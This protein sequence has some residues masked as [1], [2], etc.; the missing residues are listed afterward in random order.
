MTERASGAGH[1]PEPFDTELE[2][3]LRAAL[4]ARAL[5]ITEADLRPPRPPALPAETETP[6]AVQ[7]MGRVRPLGRPR[8]IRS[9]GVRQHRSAP[10]VAASIAALLLAGGTVALWHLDSIGHGTTMAD[11]TPSR[12]ASRSP[13][14][15]GPPPVAPPVG[16]PA[17]PPTPY[18]IAFRTES[19]PPATITLTFTPQTQPITGTTATTNAPRVSATGGDPAVRKQV[20]STIRASITRLVERYR[21]R[22]VNSGETSAGGTQSIT[23]TAEARWQHTLSLV[24]NVADDNPAT[25]QQ[26]ASSAAIVLDRRSGRA[27]PVSALFSDLNAVDGLVRQALRATTPPGA[28]TPAALRALTLRPTQDPASDPVTWYPAPNGLH[29]TIDRQ[30]LPGGGTGQLSATVGWARLSPFLSADARS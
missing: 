4:S 22:L 2:A 25:G 3:L 24:L 1:Q 11:P 28:L 5:Q 18:S 19:H 21:E 20:V 10:A 9:T 26:T 17:P 30:T 15:D 27:V 16:P 12:T 7:P 14:P 13:S 8:P 29:V 23:V 6:G